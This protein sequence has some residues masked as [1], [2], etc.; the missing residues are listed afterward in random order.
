MVLLV[1]AV[2]IGLLFAASGWIGIGRWS[3]YRV[4]KASI[5]Q[6]FATG[7]TQADR[8]EYESA[9]KTYQSLLKIDPTNRAA[10][11]LQV[12]AAMGWLEDF[13]VL[14]PDGAKAEDLAGA[15]LAEI[16]PVLD[17]GLAR[18][19][20]QRPRAADILAHIGWAHWLNQHLAYRE[21]GPAAERDLRQALRIDSSN[22]FAHAM[23]GNWIM[24]TGGRT[25]E[26]LLHFRIAGEGN[27]ERPFV[28]RL[29]LGAMIYPADP[30]TRIA[31]IRV[32][33]EMRRN[34]EPID[35]RPR[36]Q[37]LAAYNPIV[38]SAE[39]LSETLSAVPP[40]DA[41]AT[42]LWLDA[43]RTDGADLDQQRIQHDFIHASILEIERKQ[44]EALAA[45][46][47]LRSE[48]KRRGYDGRIA[49]HVDKAIT[50][51]STP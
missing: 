48:L 36:R 40:G 38:N 33:N 6:M 45:F 49:S 20:G 30:E 27:K 3:E 11:D 10:M 16:M 39:E 2:L 14:A 29:Q 1:T 35:D 12:D 31:L 17:A 8:A 7:R 50:R 19:T 4:R 41:W 22:V 18:A 37:I 28:R 32:A 26:A 42:Y 5:D 23:L 25:E 13:H 43:Q 34:G 46:E 21:F 24:Q 9:F 44:Q 47:R 51:L 15:L